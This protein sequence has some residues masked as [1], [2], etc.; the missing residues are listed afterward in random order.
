MECYLPA[1]SLSLSLIETFVEALSSSRFGLLPRS[2]EAAGT[3]GSVGR[4]IITAFTND[5]VVKYCHF[6]SCVVLAARPDFA[7]CKGKG[8]VFPLQALSGLEGG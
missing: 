5:I 2:E 1:T 8:K 4:G 6:N 3:F 7:S